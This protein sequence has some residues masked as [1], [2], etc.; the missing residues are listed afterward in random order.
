MKDTSLTMRAQEIILAAD[1]PVNSTDAL[2]QALRERSL[3][4]DELLKMIASQLSTKSLRNSTYNIPEQ[5]GLFAAPSVIAISTA[6]GDLF[7]KGEIATNDQMA[8]WA[9]EGLQHH[10]TQRLRFKRAKKD[11]ATVTEVAGDGSLPYSKSRLMI[12]GGDN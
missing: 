10:S 9:D 11:I 3:S 5:D 6:D 8:Q 7:I 1:R 12:T 4:Y 2:V